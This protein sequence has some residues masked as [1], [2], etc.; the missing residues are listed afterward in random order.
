MQIWGRFGRGETGIRIYF[1]YFSMKKKKENFFD[2]KE[3]T[4]SQ[5]VMETEQ[6]IV[7]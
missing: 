3:A 4:I 6:A 1:I 2:L 7:A 5:F